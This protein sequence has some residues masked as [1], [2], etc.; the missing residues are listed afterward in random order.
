[1]IL[2]MILYMAVAIVGIGSFGAN[3]WALPP[4]RKRLRWKWRRDLGIPGIPQIL[5]CW[6]H[7]G[8]LGVLLICYWASR[9]CCWPWASLDLPP[10]VA[11]IN[12]A[13]TTL[14]SRDWIAVVIAG[15]L[16]GNVRTTWS[17]SAFT[18]LIY[19]ALTNLAALQLSD[20]E[21]LYPRLDR[22]GRAGRC[23]FLPSGS[24]PSSG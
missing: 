17:F 8:M 7:Y 5:V 16:I 6:R 9:G 2:T 14:T 20:Q 1:M 21:R 12:A 24:R 15:G 13:G 23:H 22:L 19:Y 11:R 18:V 3:G 10:A 4:S